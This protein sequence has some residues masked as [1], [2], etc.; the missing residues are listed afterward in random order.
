MVLRVGLVSRYP[1]VHCGVGEYTRMLVSGFRRVA[2]G[3]EVVVF[4]SSEA[5]WESYVDVELGVSIRPSY[6]RAAHSY[7]RLL[8]ELA[9]VGVLTCFMFNTSMGSSGG[10]LAY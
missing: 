5:G 7:E 9:E 3:T 10:I 8:D 4:S 2:P 1:P 6:D